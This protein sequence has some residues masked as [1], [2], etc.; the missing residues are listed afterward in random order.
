MYPREWLEKGR[1]SSGN[2]FSVLTYNV[3]A[4]AAIH[5]GHYEYC[6]EDRRYMSWRHKHIMVEIETMQPD[7]VC[8]QEVH[9]SHWLN[10]LLP[11]MCSLGF[12]GVLFWRQDDLCVALCY[13]TAVFSLKKHTY[14]LFHEILEEDIKVSLS[15]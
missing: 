15:I 14:K 7:V 1:P 2:S 11:D 8:F 3:L 10:H 5:K 4:D 12:D 6:P 13:R 9:E